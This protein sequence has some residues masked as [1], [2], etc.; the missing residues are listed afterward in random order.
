MSG[1]TSPQRVLVTGATGYVGGR[2]VPELL[3]R[4]YRVRAAA[5]TVERLR[6]RPWAAHPNVELVAADVLD[7]D[8]L[9]RAT[10]GAWAVYYLVHSM[11]PGTAEF[12]DTDRRGAQNMA[13][14]AAGLRRLIY[15]GGLG[16]A[17][18]DLSEHLRSRA[19]VADTLRAGSVPVTVLRAAMLIG[20]G[21]ASFEILRY[22]VDRLPL[23]ITPRWLATISQPIAVSNAI[24]Y[25]VGCLEHDETTGQT[26]DIGGPELVTYRTLMETYAD[27][28]GLHRPRIIAVPVLTPRLSSYWIQLV[29]PV[30]A[31][32]SRPLVEGLRNPMVCRDGRIRDLI[33]QQLLTPREAIRRALEEWRGP[34]LDHS[35]IDAGHG[36]PAEWAVP[37]DP[38]WAGGRAY[39]D[40]R[41][42]E[43]EASPEAVW[44][45]VHRIG[46]DT[47]W[48][49]V[50][51]LWSLR[52]GLDRLLGGVGLRRG[53]PAR[54][55]LEAGDAV[56]FW[57]VAAIM[58]NERLVL[59]A[60]MR[61]PGRAWLEFQLRPLGR[62][63][64][65]LAQTAWFLPRGWVG[66]L[67]WY[68]IA[69][70]HAIVFGRML[71]GISR[72]ATGPAPLA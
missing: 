24:A 55:A 23:M 65:E 18:G 57:R 42:V 40:S 48:Y 14:A 13:Q 61:L 29:T 10:A 41:R 7:L 63:G 1:A 32:L 67:Y 26:Y 22:L 62:G 71:R 33:P 56:D 20:S 53:R 51:W 27:E 36:A 59:E 72:A 15:L 54:R 58:P 8:S 49:A 37:G 21:S 46:G 17:A 52:G 38:S 28:A 47:G 5:R 39:V 12:S 68:A 44:D 3:R 4:G 35:R 64:T 45:V 6:T 50:N 2:L 34:A 70:F 66:V 16:E 9:R 60:E 30:P 11:A 31:A 43:L 69:P 19:E 25:L